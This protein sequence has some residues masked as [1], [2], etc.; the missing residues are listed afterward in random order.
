ML[1][2]GVVQPEPNGLAEKRKTVQKVSSEKFGTR[3]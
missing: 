2:L 1:K 3:E